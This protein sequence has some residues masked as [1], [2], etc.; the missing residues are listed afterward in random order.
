MIMAPTSSLSLNIGTATSERAPPCLAA[1]PGTGSAIA[2]SVWTMS[3]LR[4]RRSRVP[5]GVGRD[6]PTPLPHGFG[7]LKRY[8]SRRYRPKYAIAVA[9]QYP[10]LCFTNAHGVRQHGL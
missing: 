10:E 5:K 6:L 4:C 2:S 3:L 1:G 9:K 8:I 7:V